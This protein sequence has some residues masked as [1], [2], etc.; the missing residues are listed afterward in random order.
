MQSSS[1]EDKEII[2]ID[3][4]SSDGSVEYLKAKFPQ[5]KFI[6]NDTN[7]GFAKACNQG[8]AIS[9]GK[10]VLFLNPDTIVAEDTLSTA[11]NFLQSNE[12]I[13]AVGVR[14]ID[15]K[16]NFLK[17]SKR[18]FP[19]PVTSLFKLF[20]FARVFP[21]SK[22]FSRYHLGHLDENHNH[23]VDVLAGAFMMVKRKVLQKCGTFDETFFMYG[24]DVDLSYRIQKNGYKN[25]YVADASII[26]F[27][28]ESTKRG[29]FNYVR[30]FYNAMSI[31][32][33]KHYGG[34]K[35]GLFNASIHFAIWVRALLSAA[36]KF[37]KWIGLPIIDA[38]LILLSFLFIK[39]VWSTY[40][41]PEIDYPDRLLLI[42]LPSFT[43]VYLIV[44][45]YAGL[46]N[47]NYRT[48]DLIRSTSIATLVLLAAYSMLPEQFR[49]SRAIVLFGALVAFIIISIVRW[50]M[51]TVG[52]LEQQQ[53]NN[54][55]P[56]II[57]GGSN[58]EVEE[59]KNLLGENKR[60]KKILGS[61]IIKD[62]K[63]KALE[64]IFESAATLNAKE[65]ILCSGHLSNND[66]I[67]ALKKNKA[68]LRVRFHAAGSSS[69]VGSDSSG[70]SGEVLSSHTQ[71]NLG[72][73]HY[74]R[75]KRL[76]DILLALFF[77]V[78]FFIHLIFLKNKKGFIQNCISVLF[79]KNTWVGYGAVNPRLPRL[80]KSII[81]SNGSKINGQSINVEGLKTLD[82]WYAKNYQPADDF[83]SIYQNYK[84][85]GKR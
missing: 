46:Y 66:I 63:H 25:F 8:Y 9:K 35:A 4:Q 47:K 76:F 6:C 11:V 85:L 56:N 65:L 59:V 54:N 20:G 74:R 44:G 13:G 78:T 73:A 19:G 7:L 41:R 68:N 32:V 40:V 83:I 57:I 42:A 48:K 17:E 43:I 18:A 84:E 61:I 49:F 64:K 67:E 60:N 79:G 58:T 5:I 52:L 39:E 55:Q 30:M 75:L 72:Q 53:E 81:S 45:Y 15:G 10:N 28:G 12:D 21:K 77:L 71:F 31:F 3:N 27:K 70:T 37:I 51:L 33:Q 62:E 26:H 16:G 1:L 82:Y 22:S 50:M 24:E 14:M 34:T 29:S 80:K 23:E 2:V 69:I 38:I 36:A